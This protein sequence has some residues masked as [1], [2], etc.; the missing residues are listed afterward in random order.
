MPINVLDGTGG[1]D[2][3]VT[4]RYLQR[5]VNRIVKY[6]TDAVS[7]GGFDPSTDIEF[8]GE[9][10][11]SDE[12]DF[13][14]ATVT[15]IGSRSYKV[16]TALITQVGEDAPTVVVLENTFPS[17]IVWSKTSGDRYLGT[18]AGAFT[19]NK[20][21][22]NVAILTNAGSIPLEAARISDDAV[23]IEMSTGGL[24]TSTPIEIRVYD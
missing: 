9:V 2:G 11:F 14:G 5:V 17:A 13:S 6:I 22:V 4:P 8:T 12:V 7:T 16:Y 10:T 24:L 23:R 21:W 19:A 3:K 18:L 15:G 1:Y 20:T